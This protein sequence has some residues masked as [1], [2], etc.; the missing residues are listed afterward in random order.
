MAPHPSRRALAL[1]AAAVGAL[2]GLEVQRRHLGRLERDGDYVALSAPLGGRP[3]TVTS[4][5]GTRL[6]V[7]RFGPEA[8]TVVV[9]AHGWTE[10]LNLWGPV[11]RRL[12]DAGLQPV[13]YD[14]RGHG[15]SADAVDG[16]Y[17]LERFGDDVEAVLAAA[18]PDGERGVVA[19][20][21]LG[22]MSIA[23]WADRHDV[24]RRVHAAALINTALGDLVTGHLLLGELA[25][26]FEHPALSRLLMGSGLRVP[27]FSTPL[28]QA[29]VRHAAF[30]P[31]A[32]AGMVAFY[33]R[34][35]IECAPAARA[36]AG[37]ALTDM[38]LWEA[39]A[40]LTVPTLVVCGDRDR[41]TP[42][43]QA[44]RIADSLPVPAGLV[45][46]EAT[47]HMGPL[48]RPT[49]I[50]EA[51]AGPHLERGPHGR[52]HRLALTAPVPWRRATVRPV[53]AAGIRASPA[54][55]RSSCAPAA[56]RAAGCSTRSGRSPRV[57]SPPRWPGT[58]P[59]VCSAIPSPSSPRSQPRSR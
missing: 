21:S 9:L 23:A 54:S 52:R 41:L 33:E 38:N 1:A 22:G 53:L 58:S 18:L 12:V 13:A 6:N 19:G 39:V 16:D 48:E 34:M 10:R 42:P 3:L 45:V 43:A 44:R 30:G 14:L 26:R 57:R 5:D 50:A 56:T 59:T 25:K 35:L 4:A 29:V 36:A 24:T 46:L 7:E 11:I 28:Q 2:A 55:R 8:G 27:P 15:A 17:S 40:Q 51:L 49:Q 32:T 31:T 37:I 20:H 47:G